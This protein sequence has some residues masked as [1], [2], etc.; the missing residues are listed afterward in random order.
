VRRLDT[1]AAAHFVLIATMILHAADH[2]RQGIGDLTPEVLW[3][4]VALGA[5]VLAT[6]PLTLRRHPRAPLAAAVVGLGTAAAVSASHLAPHWSAFSD[7]YPDLSV[8]AWSWGAM[9]AEIV[10]ALAFAVVGLGAFRRVAQPAPA[11]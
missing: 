1:L 3:G 5:V 6:L 9:L 8:D 2:L 7:P 4:G 10:A 11:A